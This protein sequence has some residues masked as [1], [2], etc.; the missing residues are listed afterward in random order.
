MPPPARVRSRPGS[1]AIA[2]DFSAG[3]GSRSRPRCPQAG[4]RGRVWGQHL[5]GWEWSP[6]VPPYVVYAG[7]RRDGIGSGGRSCEM[8]SQVQVLAGPLPATTSKNADPRHVQSRS[9]GCGPDDT[10]A[11]HDGRFGTSSDDSRPLS[12]CGLA[13]DLPHASGLRNVN[14]FQEVLDAFPVVNNAP[15]HPYYGGTLY[16]KCSSHSAQP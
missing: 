12:C 3:K 1:R 14:E 16:P 9:D 2:G 4:L 7:R 13:P 6:A 10:S 11:P 5:F 15:D 8:R